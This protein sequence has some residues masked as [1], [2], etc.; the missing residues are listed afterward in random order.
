MFFSAS[1]ALALASIL[2]PPSSAPV[3]SRTFQQQVCTGPQ[4]GGSCTPLANVCTN[5]PGIQS[6]ILN[7]DADCAGFPLPNCQFNTGQTVLELFSD[8]SQFLGGKGIQSVL[9]SNI[10]GTVNGFTAGS[11]EDLAQ[12]AVDQEN[13]VFFD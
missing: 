10:A 4:G 7:L 1:I 13:G 3:T 8:D 6:L 9:C 12:E 5:T 11:P 2:S